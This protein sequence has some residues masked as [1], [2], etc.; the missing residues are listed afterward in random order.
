L[1]DDVEDG[2][3]MI[4]PVDMRSGPWWIASDNCSYLPPPAP[5]APPP[6]NG[7]V[8]AIHFVVSGCTSWGFVAGLLLNTP[9]K[10]CTYDASYYDGIYFWAKSSG[11]AVSIRFTP[12]TT[13]TIPIE[14]GGDGTCEASGTCWQSHGVDLVFDANWR[15][16]AMKWSDLLQPSPVQTVAF[17]PS[18]IMHFKWAGFAGPDYDLWIDQVGFFKGEAP[19]SP[20]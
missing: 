8:A 3:L 1:V 7:S 9:D 11:A 20:P 15:L 14:N 19:L 16:Y 2:D 12:E 17:D 18:I 4:R 10:P 6:G 13:K 5:E